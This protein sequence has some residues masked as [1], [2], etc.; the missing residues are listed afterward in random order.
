MAASIRLEE[1]ISFP[2]N[3]Q[4]EQLKNSMA[5]NRVQFDETI[6]LKS[7]I[8]LSS[9]RAE[10]EEREYLDGEYSKSDIREVQKPPKRPSNVFNRLSQPKN[11][12]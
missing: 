1:Q 11:F 4:D 8:I 2:N 9:V 5:E 10:K 12:K 3:Q 6:Q 7:E